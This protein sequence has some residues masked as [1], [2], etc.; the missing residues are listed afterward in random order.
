MINN[1]NSYPQ[2]WVCSLTKSCDTRRW[3]CDAAQHCD[4]HRQGLIH[5]MYF[6]IGCNVVTMGR[7]SLVGSHLRI[8]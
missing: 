7:M 4:I 3:V 1:D 5:I 6:S 2:F 8:V